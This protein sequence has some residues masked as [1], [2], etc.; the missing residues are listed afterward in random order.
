MQESSREAIQDVCETRQEENSACFY[1]S[2][3][4]HQSQKDRNEKYP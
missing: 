1:N 4:D 3:M 2:F